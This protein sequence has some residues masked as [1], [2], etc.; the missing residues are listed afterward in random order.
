MFQMWVHISTCQRVSAGGS[1]WLPGSVQTKAC[2]DPQPGWLMQWPSSL[3][4]KVGLCLAVAVG[5]LDLEIQNFAR[6]KTTS[7][8]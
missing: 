3:K 1:Y 2:C 7:K 4:E 8:T 5:M 6:F